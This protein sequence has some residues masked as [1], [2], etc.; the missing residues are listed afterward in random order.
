MT[1][2]MKNEVDKLKKNILTVCSLVE[3]NVEKAV[4]SVAN[5]DEKL[6]REVIASDNQVDQ[7]EVE[8]EEECLKIL[9]L[10]QPVAIDL[11]YVV[12]ILKINNDLERIGDQAVNIAKQA[13]EFQKKETFKVPV[14]FSDMVKKT[15]QMLNHALDAMINLDLEKAQA[16]LRSDDDVDAIHMNMYT[17]IEGKIKEQPTQ[18]NLLIRTLSVSRNLER[19]ADYA[20]NIAEDVIYMIKGKIIRHGVADSY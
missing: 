4:A 18:A 10:Y 16:V 6:A 13:I 7:N 20:T 3:Q 14:D 15:Q 2:L 8:V 11:R 1:I 17:I 5:G 12:A 19:I 9:A